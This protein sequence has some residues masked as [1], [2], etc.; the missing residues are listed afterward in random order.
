[1]SRAGDI[2]MT[3]GTLDRGGA[4]GSR[5]TCRSSGRSALPRRAS[6]TTRYNSVHLYKSVHLEYNSVHLQYNSVHLEYNGV[7]LE[8]NGVHSE[9]DVQ[10]QWEIGPAKARFIDNQV[11]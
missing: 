8:Y 9:K 5:R 7:H 1:M 11:Q 2:Y 10:K 3:C 4:S 6:S